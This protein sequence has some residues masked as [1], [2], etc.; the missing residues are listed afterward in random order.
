MALLVLFLGME[1]NSM[2]KF[3]EEIKS[4]MNLLQKHLLK[5]E[6]KAARESGW[7]VG[8]AREG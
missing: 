4:G 6:L 7:V 5:Q 3:L 8:A 1:E 2:D